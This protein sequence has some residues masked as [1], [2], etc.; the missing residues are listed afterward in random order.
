MAAARKP[1]NRVRSLFAELTKL[2]VQES[3]VR[4]FA[5]PDWWDDEI[6]ETAAGRDE[7]HLLLAQLLGLDVASLR[8]GR[9]RFVSQPQSK[10]K[11]AKGL[12]ATDIATTRHIAI[13]I[14]RL[15]AL[16]VTQ[17]T[18]VPPD[19]AA[20]RSAI[21]RAGRSWVD[22]EGLL[23]YCWSVGVAVVHVEAWPRNRRRMAAV[24]ATIDGRPVIVVADKHKH[25]GWLLFHVAHELGHLACGHVP[26]AAVLVDAEVDR[27][28][29]DREE[30]EANRF[31]VELLTG[32]AT[33]RVLPA[34]RWPK[35]PDLAQSALDHASRSGID[36]GHFVLNYAA[37]MGPTFF[38]VANAALR[39]I[40]PQADAPGLI[41]RKLA[42][43]LDW[44]KLPGTSAE[45]VQRVVGAETPAA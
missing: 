9:A 40:E 29:R 37:S 3:Y 11:A 10:L 44:S 45:F 33:T 15:V 20:A 23:D 22:L 43:N 39:L 36:P 12:A 31:A 32:S 28:S 13:Q 4:R 7:L 34:D 14:A 5:L 18:A 19:A 24:V 42:E 2:G 35:A 25:T 1:T 8:E 26:A 27:E 30:R 41:R 17:P 21:L 6:A 16:G 38:A